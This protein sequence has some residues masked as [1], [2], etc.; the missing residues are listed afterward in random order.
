MGD[1]KDPAI[2]G[3]GFTEAGL[4]RRITVHEAAQV[5]EIDYTGLVIRSS[6][7]ANALYDRIEARIL[8]TGEPLWFFCVDTTDYRI[9][10]SAWFAYSRRSTDMHDAHSMGTVRVDRAAARQIEQARGTDRENPN[11]F[12]SREA[13]MADLRARPSRRRIRAGHVPSFTR[14]EIQGRIRLDPEAGIAEVDLSGLS[15]EHSRDVN[16]VFNWI[17]ERVRPT[18][19]RWYFLYNYE[20]TRIQQPA[21]LTY[22]LRAESLRDAYSLGSVRYAAGSE[23]ERDIRL[24]AESR[25][26]RPNIR[27]TRAEALERIDEMKQA[28]ERR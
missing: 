1:R 21:W 10:S 17:E 8:E 19:R 22:S 3:P 11:L 12:A 16:D 27:N 28:A 25:T 4:D 5:I 26:Q 13:A 23:T 18:G 20:G 7:E 2:L 14:A 24:R 9:D 15:L 6:A